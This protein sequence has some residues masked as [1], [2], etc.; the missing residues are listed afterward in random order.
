[1][2]RLEAELFRTRGDVYDALVAS[3]FPV[4]IA[5]PSFDTSMGVALSSGLGGLNIVVAHGKRPNWVITTTLPSFEYYK[6]VERAA[7]HSKPSATESLIGAVQVREET[8]TVDVERIL[9]DRP[10]IHK[11]LTEEALAIAS[12]IHSGEE[13][14]YTFAELV[15]RRDALLAGAEAL[16]KVI[17]EREREVAEEKARL[18]T[19][20]AELLAKLETIR[21]RK[22]ELK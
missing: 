16:T 6:F 2:Q 7:V 5:R 22:A 13:R 17:A 4:K 20:E 9:E 15:A 1:V 8:P 10:E 18:E 11:A 14:T 3:G 21:A 19:E 12:R